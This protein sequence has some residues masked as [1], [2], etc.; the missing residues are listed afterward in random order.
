LLKQGRRVG[1]K[2]VIGQAVEKYTEGLN[3][4]QKA[5]LSPKPLL[6]ALYSNRAFAESILG[7]WRNALDSANWAIRTDGS[8]LKSYFRAAKAAQELKRWTDALELCARAL[9]IEPTAQELLDIHKVRRCVL[10]SSAV[11]HCLMRRRS[12]TSPLWLSLEMGGQST[13]DIYFFF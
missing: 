1:K 2:L 5:Q 10:P 11:G 13:H 3:I 4:L 6:T 8:H 7:N 12:L 9:N